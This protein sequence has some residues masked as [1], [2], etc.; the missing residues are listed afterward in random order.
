[1]DA[2]IASSAKKYAA[3]SSSL[4]QQAVAPSSQNS[5]A[6]YGLPPPSPSSIAATVIGT[7]LDDFHNAASC[8][9]YNRYFIHFTSDAIFLGSDPHE[10]W[11]I[12]QFK[13]YAF[14]RFH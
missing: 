4:F 5:N 3:A 12:S 11:N 13:E 8:G 7:I 6:N 14:P 9:N 10:R 2:A 1:M